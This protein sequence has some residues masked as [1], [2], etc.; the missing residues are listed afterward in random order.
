M[1]SLMYLMAGGRNLRHRDGL[2][3]EDKVQA[4]SRMTSTMAGVELVSMT[5]TGDQQQVV[6]SPGLALL[7]PAKKTVGCQLRIITSPGRNSQHSD[8]VVRMV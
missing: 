6:G 2:E 7:P 1:S 3:R 5:D 4:Q 8:K